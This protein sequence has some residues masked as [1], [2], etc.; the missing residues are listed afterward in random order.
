MTAHSV[1]MTKLLARQLDS[2]WWHTLRTTF[3][4][5]TFSPTP[6]T[7]CHC[8]C[9]RCTHTTLFLRR[10]NR[11]WKRLRMNLLG[12]Y[13]NVTDMTHREAGL[14]SDCRQCHRHDTLGSMLCIRLQAMSQCHRHDTPGSM[15]CVRLQAMSWTWHTGKQALRQTSGNVTD[16]THWEACF[17]SVWRNSECYHTRCWL[18]ISVWLSDLVSRRVPQRPLLCSLYQEKV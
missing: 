7:P 16:M 12:S 17:A 5:S 13:R 18:M 9:A 1:N 3:G 11:P 8:R 4:K 14:A 6:Y 15:L 2:T 10:Q